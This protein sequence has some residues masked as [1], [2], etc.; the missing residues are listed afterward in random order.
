MARTRWPSDLAT[1]ASCPGQADQTGSAGGCQKTWGPADRSSR[2][3]A[4]AA[5]AESEDRPAPR[6]RPYAHTTAKPRKQGRKHCPHSPCRIFVSDGRAD[7]LPERLRIIRFCARCCLRVLAA[8]IS[9]NPWHFV[10]RQPGLTDRAGQLGLGQSQRVRAAS[11]LVTNAKRSRLARAR[12]L[13]SGR[14]AGCGGLAGRCRVRR[15]RRR[16][17]PGPAGRA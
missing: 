9:I 14:L 16:P 5:S 8:M 10:A 4:R 12:V 3:T 1:P 17:A 6:P 13:F 7:R 15:R 2:R 11:P